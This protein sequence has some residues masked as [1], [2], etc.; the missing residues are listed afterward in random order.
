MTKLIPFAS[1]PALSKS[2]SNTDKTSM[3]VDKKGVPVGFVFGRD[4]LISFLE[5]ID[6][7]F[8]KKVTD[9]VKAWNNPAGMLIDAIEE[10]LPLDDN[11]ILSL[12]ESVVKLDEKHL[13]SLE[14]IAKLLHV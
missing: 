6:T 12:K 9:P 11:F 10:K 5:K 1:V 3:V 2:F 7:E 14:E 8:E 4:A 13:I